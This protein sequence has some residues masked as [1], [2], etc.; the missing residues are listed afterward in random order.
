MVARR[1]FSFVYR[2]KNS[3]RMCTES[4]TAIGIRKM[5]IIELMMCTGK[6]KAISRPIVESTETIAT[7]M[8]EMTSTSL[9]KNTS[10]RMKMTTIASGAEIAIWMNIS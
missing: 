5:G 2:S 7:I 8:G 9:R 1:P 10:I 6:P 4:T 3:D